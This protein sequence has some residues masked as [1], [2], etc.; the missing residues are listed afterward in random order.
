MIV[1]GVESGI[2]V[3][4]LPDKLISSYVA[5]G[6]LSR[7]KIDGIELKRPIFFIKHRDK[8]LSDIMKEVISYG[9]EKFGE[10]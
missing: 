8:F 3:S 10:K 7:L 9:N 6:K 2:G 4:V 1:N 5:E